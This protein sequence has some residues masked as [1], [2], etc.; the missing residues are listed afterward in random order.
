MG[1]ISSLSA[2]DE[3]Q[4]RL[5]CVRLALGDLDYA[6]KLYEFVTGGQ[7]RPTID[8]R[9]A[10][11]SS[12]LALLDRDAGIRRIIREELEAFVAWTRFDSKADDGAHDDA[13]R[14]YV[15]DELLP[16]MDAYLKRKAERDA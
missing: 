3:A 5:E 16:Q 12:D 9:G 1:Q 13:V 6:A 14:A 4:L 7:R 8:A 2:E 15:R 10:K 11:L